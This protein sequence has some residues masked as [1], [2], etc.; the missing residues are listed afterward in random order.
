MLLIRS[1][2]K[3]TKT[4]LLSA[5]LGIKQG[6]LVGN[7]TSLFPS[8]SRV[9]TRHSALLKKRQ[10]L[11]HRI[12]ASMIPEDVVLSRE[13]LI[14]S[15][16]METFRVAGVTF[17]DRQ[18]LLASLTPE[19]SVVLEK[20][21][22]NVYDPNAVAVKLLDDEK[23][24]YV[25]KED[26]GKFIHSL[27]F[28]KLRSIGPVETSSGDVLGCLIDTQPKL[29][30][31]IPL[32]LPSDLKRDCR[33]FVGALTGKE[34]ESYKIELI[35]AGGRRCS[36]TRAET[37]NIEARWRILEDEK[38]V[39]LVG[40][41]L[42]HESISAIQ[43]LMDESQIMET[44]ASIEIMNHIAEEEALLFCG[45]QFEFSENRRG[46]FSMDIS[47]LKDIGLK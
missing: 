5:T 23:M 46:Q 17:E 32:A 22:E 39:K 25:P 7:Y 42:Q 8:P 38:V 34:W 20:E 15:L 24:G 14:R 35:A 16:P 19:I 13:R 31:V 21:P 29:P 11:T 27:C 6:Q 18:S 12:K 28:G 41:A 2:I 33:D 37:E 1:C 10:R 45:R 9:S 3:K 36:I 43:Y 40:F 26:T 47:Y 4:G 30:P 44:C